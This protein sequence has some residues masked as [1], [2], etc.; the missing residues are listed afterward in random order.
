[1]SLVVASASTDPFGLGDEDGAIGIVLRAVNRV[2]ELYPARAFY[3]LSKTEIISVSVT[4]HSSFC[5]DHYIDGLETLS[6]PKQFVGIEQTLSTLLINYASP[7]SSLTTAIIL[8][9]L[10][11]KQKRSSFF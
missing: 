8:S 5:C 2:P 4:L 7:S 6:S 10:M 9:I 3:D 11:I 1:M